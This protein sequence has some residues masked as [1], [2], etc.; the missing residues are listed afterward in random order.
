MFVLGALVYA[1]GYGLL[2]VGVHG[3]PLLLAAF[4]LAGMGIGFAE[5]AESN[6]VAQ[7]VPEELGGNGFGALGLTQALGDLGS[8]AVAGI[9]WTVVGPG[10]AF[11]YAAAWMAAALITGRLLGP[12]Q[13]ASSRG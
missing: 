1:A 2:A 5:T 4:A 8:T 7:A 12:S 9:L 13:P 6:A 10:A 3:W 11:G